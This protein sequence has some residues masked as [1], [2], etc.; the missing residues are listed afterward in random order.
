MPA[1][2]SPQRGVRRRGTHRNCRGAASL[3]KPLSFD[4]FPGARSGG[5]PPWGVV[6]PFASEHALRHADY[7]SAGCLADA[8]ALDLGFVVLETPRP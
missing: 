7:Y 3:V 2:R 8:G 5:Q 1:E 6:R 4:R